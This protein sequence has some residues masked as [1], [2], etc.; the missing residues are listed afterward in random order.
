MR[1]FQGPAGRFGAARQGRGTAGISSGGNSN[2]T[3]QVAATPPPSR[4]QAQEVV[5]N[6]AE[7]EGIQDEVYA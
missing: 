5:V 1:R 7:E 6:V 3:T 2:P 4:A